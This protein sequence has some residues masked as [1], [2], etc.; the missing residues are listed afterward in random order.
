MITF[1]FYK[2][3]YK[4]WFKTD[5]NFTVMSTSNKFKR[6]ISLFIYC[7]YYSSQARKTE[8]Q[9]ST[10]TTNCASHRYMHFLLLHI[11]GKIFLLVFVLSSSAETNLKLIDGTVLKTVVKSLC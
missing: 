1:A 4:N 7:Y 11:T 3:K 6:I 2:N 8:L 10:L 5:A 9:F